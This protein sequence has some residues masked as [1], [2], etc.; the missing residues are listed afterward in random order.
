[1]RSDTK[2]PK[3]WD[4]LLVYTQPSILKV[5]LLGFSSGLPLLLLGSTLS[6]RLTESGLDLSTIGLFALVGIPYSIK[7]LWAPFVDQLRLPFIRSHLAHRKSWAILS[8]I[9]LALCFVALALLDPQLQTPLIAAFALLTAFFSS[10]QDIIID[11]LRVELLE[12]EDQGAGAGAAVLGYRIGMLLAGAGAMFAA[13]YY[14]WSA[15]YGGFAFFML[16]G[17]LTVLSITKLSSKAEKA[18][19]KDDEVMCKNENSGALC[20]IKRAVILP[21]VDFFRRDG[22]I[23]I[24]LFIALFKLG[25]A[26]AGAMT[27]P[28]YLK[29]DY[30]KIEIASVSKVFGLIATLGGALIGGVLV[31]RMGMMKSLILC[32]VLQVLSNF[33]F[34]YL[35]VTPH[36]VFSLTWV[37]AVENVAGG[38]GTAAFVA[39]LSSLCS[40]QFTAT[41]YALLSSLSSVGR[42][43]LSS[44][45]G[46]LAEQF[47][48]AFFFALTAFFGVPG[49][50]LL[51][52]LRRR[53]ATS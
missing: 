45:S 31:K 6:A 40:V 49:L 29:M 51:L 24:L 10:L 17:I 4:A 25:D 38:M 12:D 41:Q 20:W 30:S 43:L 7:F 8:Q 18:R 35:A 37:I 9:C 15:V 46:V 21:F 23:L 19:A 14:S 32:G 26:M 3:L 50:V 28:F 1:M 34:I 22:A 16:P 33:A 44:T 13:S 52:L 48:W 36:S 27:M 5:L 11:A 42:S 47:G 39:Y 2:K 53:L